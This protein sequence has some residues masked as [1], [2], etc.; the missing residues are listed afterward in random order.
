MNGRDLAYTDDTMGAL[1]KSCPFKNDASAIGLRFGRLVVVSI[2]SYRKNSGY[3]FNF[4]CKCDCGG[5]KVTRP[6]ALFHGYTKSCGCLKRENIQKIK[7][8]IRTTHGLCKKDGVR[9]PEYRALYM[10]IRRCH[11][12]KD[13]Y[14]HCYGG[15]GISVFPEWRDKE[16]GI[17]KFLAHIGKRPSDFHSLDRIDVNG[18][19]EPG[20]VQWATKRQQ[21]EN[22][23]PSKAITN[24]TNEELMAEIT[25]RVSKGELAI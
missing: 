23:R 19:Y 18:N 13:D 15:R 7:E 4:L 16:H 20:N 8:T 9:F 2:Y 22:R 11:N 21:L 10:A 25:R 12:P 14:Y 5:E 1:R 6:S 3:P 24:F 17:E